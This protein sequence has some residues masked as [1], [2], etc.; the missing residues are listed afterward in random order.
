MVWN[1][2]C[3][4]ANNALG[5]SKQRNSYQSS[6]TFLCF[7]SPTVLFASQ[8]NLFCTMLPDCVKGLLQ[9][10]P[11]WQIDHLQGYFVWLF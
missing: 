2:L 11:N 7:D 8:H 1:K 5:L 10:L 6:L 4:D 3:W 9:T